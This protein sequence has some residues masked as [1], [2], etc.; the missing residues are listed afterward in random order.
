MWVLAAFL[1]FAVTVNGDRDEVGFGRPNRQRCPAGW[2]TFERICYKFFD[3]LKTWAEA[4]KQC[5][6]LDGNL[7]SVHSQAT[8]NFLKDFVRGHGR[9]IPRV[10]IGAYDA[11]QDD[12]WFW[13][14]G[15]R[16]DYNNWQT[17]E[18]NNYRGPEQCVEM[19]SGGGQRW[20]DAQC[21][22][23]LNFVCK[24]SQ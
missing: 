20:N 22:T 6:D 23:Q 18:P 5:V 4:E 9:R 24:K 15:S 11:T 3:D 17:G 21:S 10:W 12:I 19:S 8:H 13:S 2:E 16:F 7:A 14:D 1:L